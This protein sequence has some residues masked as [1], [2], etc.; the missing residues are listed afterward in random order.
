MSL[1]KVKEDEKGRKYIV[2][3][4]K[5]RY[6]KEGMTKKELKLFVK[7]LKKKKKNKKKNKKKRTRATNIN[8]AKAT[9]NIIQPEAPAPTATPSTIVVPSYKDHDNDFLKGNFSN[10][11][12]RMLDD[13]K[14]DKGSKKVKSVEDLIKKLPKGERDLIKE[15][16]ITPT[17]NSDLFPEEEEPE[18][19]NDDEELRKYE[20]KHPTKREKDNM[21]YKHNES[22][23]DISGIPDDV[24]NFLIPPFRD[25]T[26]VV[27]PI[28]PRSFR[29]QTP[30]IPHQPIN[31]NINGQP[32]NQE[33]D[34]EL[35][36]KEWFR[37]M[38]NDYKKNK[39]TRLKVLHQDVDEH[40]TQ[41]ELELPLDRERIVKQRKD[42]IIDD[43]RV[44]DIFSTDFLDELLNR[45]LKKS[46]THNEDL[47]RSDYSKLNNY[48]EKSQ[49][50][51]G[52][53]DLL[54]K[55]ITK[56]ENKA[57]EMLP[58][59][60]AEEL[61]NIEDELLDEVYKPND[62]KDEK[63]EEKKEE[64][65]KTR[66]PLFENQEPQTGDNLRQTKYYLKDPAFLEMMLD[67]YLEK[68]P[69]QREQIKKDFNSLSTYEAKSNFLKGLTPLLKENVELYEAEFNNQTDWQT[70]DTIHEIESELLNNI[71]NNIGKIGYG[72]KKDDS[73]FDTDI[74]QMM[75]KIPDFLGVVA[76]DEISKKVVPNVYK[77]S[78]IAF[79]MNLDK[80]YQAGSHWVAIV[81][82]ARK[83]GSKSI[84]YFDPFGDDPDNHVLQQ[85]KNLADKMDPD[86]YLKLKINKIKHQKE[87]AS[88]CG[89]H[90]MNFILNRIQR[91]K[92]FSQA[93]GYDERIQ[94]KS[95]KYENEIQELKHKPPFDFINHKG[96]GIISTVKDW[97]SRIKQFITGRKAGSPELMKFIEKHGGEQIKSIT[98]CRQPITPMINKVLNIIT[99]GKFDKVTKDMH[100]DKLF[101]LF[102][103]FKTDSGSYITERNEIVRVYSGQPSGQTVGINVP[104][105]LNVAD[106]FT[107]GIKKVGE[108]K[109][110]TYHPVNNNCQDYLLT[111]LS[112]NGLS[113][114]KLTGFIK[115]D[116]PAVF[117]Q[118]PNWTSKLAK[119]ITDF[120]GRL[121]ALIGQG[122]EP[123]KNSS[124]FVLQ[125]K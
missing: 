113:D 122:R 9:V 82:D 74:R 77:N 54:T 58:K 51:I 45:F 120:A 30:L 41:K 109:F 71:Q 38:M 115:Q 69:E 53:S 36:N 86:T 18:E 62:R 47:I 96:A 117:K 7:L 106:F 104:K 27:T 124:K 84:E 20:R 39:D 4:K 119:G 85:L 105:N 44:N 107:N 2:F 52:L 25:P 87:N 57:T 94:D 14:K 37:S 125:K 13:F 121:R 72:K 29:R 34:E 76:S 99:L 112:A 40:S 114:S 89:Y 1:P 16:G 93:T 118:L 19:N 88:S 102:L 123:P 83:N 17:V 59:G 11:L 22:T 66:I 116:I 24:D 63:K 95:G 46:R 70:L 28:Q 31:I 79:I 50:L 55:K 61:Q 33:L 111:L 56:Y 78:R 15:K 21:D 97:V 91:N 3:D 98:I 23:N 49:F 48:R 64:G 12:E 100:Y 81:A 68:V 6:L 10:K 35:D 101:H 108:Q 32:M 75:K 8:K 67:K 26:P 110:F 60:E 42:S 73:L 90:A 65:K 92:S 5:R 80:S 43:D 103:V